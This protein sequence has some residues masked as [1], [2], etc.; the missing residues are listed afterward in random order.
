MLVMCHFFRTLCIGVL[1]GLP[2]LAGFDKPVQHIKLAYGQNKAT[3]VFKSKGADISKVESLCDCT[4]TSFSGTRLTAIVDT[5][6]FDQSVDKQLDVMTTDGKKTRL[7][8]HFDVP[9]AVILSARSLVWQRGASPEPKVLRITLPKGSPVQEVTEAAISG[10]AFIF[11]P[12]KGK[13]KREFL[14]TVAP[15]STAKRALNRLIIKTS[16]PD[17]R[18]AGFIVYLQVR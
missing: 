8:M 9:Q 1:A 13:N 12:A 3:V 6:K 15:V 18:Y 7:T 2:A 4:T 5:S 11:T 17:L 16:S 10:D 14:V